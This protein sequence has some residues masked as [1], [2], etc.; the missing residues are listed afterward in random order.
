MVDFCGAFPVWLN[1]LLLSW[2]LGLLPRGVVA[3]LSLVRWPL[4]YRIWLI[5]GQAVHLCLDI[6]QNRV[7]KRAL[8]AQYVACAVFP[9]DACAVGLVGD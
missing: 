6:F 7:P 3:L 5:H 4:E 2:I 8:D 9:G 1:R